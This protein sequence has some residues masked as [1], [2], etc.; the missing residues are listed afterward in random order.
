MQATSSYPGSTSAG[1]APCYGGGGSRSSL[2]HNII[3]NNHING[4]TAR[5]IACKNNEALRHFLY[6]EFDTSIALLKEAYGIFA[7]FRHHYYLNLLQMQQMEHQI[8]S[9]YDVH[10]GSLLSI[11]SA[12]VAMMMEAGGDCNNRDSH[13][14]EMEIDDGDYDLDRAGR[15]DNK[16]PAEPPS[17]P[18]RSSSPS[19]SSCPSASSMYNRAF[20]LATDEDDMTLL[21]TNERQ[22]GAILLYNLGLVYHNIGY[23]LG[24]SAA[25]PHSIHLYQWSLSFLDLPSYRTSMDSPYQDV[26]NCDHFNINSPTAAMHG[27]VP[28]TA[29]P[30]TAGGTGAGSRSTMAKTNERRYGDLQFQDQQQ[31]SLPN[32]HTYHQEDPKLMLAVLNNLSNLFTYLHRIPETHYALYRLRVVLA[33]SAMAHLAAVVSSMSSSA[34]ASDPP[35]MNESNNTNTTADTARSMITTGDDDY[36][37]F[38][39]NALFQGKELNFA[40]AA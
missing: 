5:A 25:V 37:W 29:V 26:V 17:Q 21:V 7:S 10:G 28:G 24:V 36:N 8:P 19:P 33:S 32:H 2:H 34:S 6:G 9:I 23:Y 22:T 39:I 31:Q 30:Q 11:T 14:V 16:H 18:P 13:N 38:F 40:P 3:N 4:S 15:R 27:G 20:V 12:S 1:T 35:T